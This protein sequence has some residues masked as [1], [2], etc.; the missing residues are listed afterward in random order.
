MKSHKALSL[1]AIQGLQLQN[2]TVSVLVQNSE[3]CSQA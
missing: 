3:I 2:F 1:E